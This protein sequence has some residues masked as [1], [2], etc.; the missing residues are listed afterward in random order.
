MIVT[1]TSEVAPTSTK[2]F[3]NLDTG[4]LV[5]IDGQINEY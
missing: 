3:S 4:F 1:F 5:E 2:P